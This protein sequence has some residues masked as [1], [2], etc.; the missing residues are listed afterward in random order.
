M[1]GVLHTSTI[2]DQIVAQKLI[3]VERLKSGP[4]LRPPVRGERPPHRFIA[5]LK[6]RE[7]RGRPIIAEVKHASPSAGVLRSP[8]DPAAIARAYEQN[9]ARC[10]SVITDEKFFQGSLEYLKQARAAAG[11][12]ILRKEF[13][14]DA[15]QIEEAWAEGADAV[16]LIARILDDALLRGLYRKAAERGLD[17]LI[18][19]HDEK[20]LE[21][22]LELRPAP[23]MIGVNNRDLSDFSVDVRRTLELLPLMP[24]EAVAVS[25]SGLSDPRVLDQLQ[26]AGVDAFLVGT[27][28]IKAPDPGAALH[29]LVYG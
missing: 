9:G 10:L 18:E 15:A 1:A 13:I 5:A 29:E 27:S 25:E 2:L 3:E 21:R 20:D 16:L 4:P 28:L 6:D 22:A 24:E 8:F 23:A 7:R 26:H 12:P 11:L 19:V 17:A 14:I